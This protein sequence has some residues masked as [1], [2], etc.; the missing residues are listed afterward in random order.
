MSPFELAEYG[1]VAAVLGLQS[2]FFIRTRRAVQIY[3]T[4]LPD[5]TSF[6]LF[7]AVVARDDLEQVPVDYLLLQITHYTARVLAGGVAPVDQISLTLMITDD[8]MKPDSVMATIQRSINTYLIRNKGAA[9]D[10]NLL[11]D[12]IQRNLDMVEEEIALTTPIP[13]YLGLIGTMIGIILGL[14]ALPDISSELF[15]K[16]NGID[17][18]LGGVK[19]AMIASAVGLI[20]TV[21]TNGWLFKGAKVRVERAKNELYTF[22]QTN[23]LP[24]LSQSVNAGVV[25]LNKSLDVFGVKFSNDISALNTL[26]QRNYE[27]IMAQ[28][29]ALTALKDMDVSRIAQFNVQVL[30]ELRQSLS[31]IERLGV[32][33]SQ[34]DSF[35]TNARALVERTQDVIGLTDQIKQVLDNAQSLQHYLNSHFQDLENRG[36][37]IQHTVG[38]L[39]QFIQR[40]ISGLEEHIQ[41]RIKAVSEIK[42]SE[43]AWMQEAMRTNQTAL[44]KLS[45]LQKMSEMS[46][47]GADFQELSVKG[48]QTL[49]DRARTTN[50]LL[51]QLLAVQKRKDWGDR[52]ANMFRKEKKMTA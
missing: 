32:A 15:L 23:L 5:V 17:S 11:R 39:D 43:D 10:F 6:R 45:H 7:D 1:L 51:Y 49:D 47:I 20:L 46:K 13:V 22:L 25:S 29:A 27:S 28:Q 19:I 24:I 9:S 48:L 12:I 26:M 30:G 38:K 52:L 14:F 37:L 31:A 41:G 33:L 2:W 42:I 34:A 16:G 18:L 21:I 35:A 50:D 44:S 36:H 8:N 40:E 3:R 4:A